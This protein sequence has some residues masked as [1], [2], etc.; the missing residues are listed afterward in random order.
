MKTTSNKLLGM[1]IALSAAIMWGTTGVAGEYMINQRGLDSAWIT[2]YRTLFGGFLMLCILFF[3]MKGEL[4][5][6]W[7][8]KSDS[9]QMVIFG[10]F[11]V[12]INLYMYMLAV[13]HTNAPTATT[14]QYLSPAMIVVYMAFI[15]KKFPSAKEIIGVACAL[16]G[17]FAISTHGNLDSLAITTTGLLIGI[18]SAF[19]LA[20]YSVYPKKL[21]AKYG[22]VYTFAWGQFVAGIL[23]NIIRCPIWNFT[24]PTD[25]N[26]DTPLLLTLAYQLIFGTMISYCIYL[27]AVTMIG[28]SICSMLSSIEPVAT[29][30]LAAL[31]LNTPLVFMDYVGCFLITLCI[32]VL[33]LPSKPKKDDIKAESGQVV[34]EQQ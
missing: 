29:A 34:S 3:K 15:N 20:F 22:S 5:K 14:L 8:N 1:V 18:A 33:S 27:I 21:L 10:L 13:Q 11:G 4:F 17:V 25:G 30:V 28:P 32:L 16:G 9:I 26:L 6:V 23:M 2:T 24:M 7:K 12:G 31:L 19:F